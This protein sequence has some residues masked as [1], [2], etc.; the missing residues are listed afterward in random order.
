G[1]GGH[2]F[3]LVAVAKKIK[4]KLGPEVEFLY[5]GSGAEMEKKVMAEEGIK[6]KFVLSGKIRR[7]FSLK[8]FG[9]FFKMPIGFLQALWIL[10]IFAPDA[11]FSKGG[12]VAVPVVLAAW[13]YRIPILMHESDSIPGVANQFLSKLA[14]RV[15]VAYPSAEQYFPAEKV[16]LTGNPIRFEVTEGDAMMLRTQLEFTAGRKTLLVLGGSLGSQAINEALTNILPQLLHSYQIIHQTGAQ[17]FDQTVAEAA[18]QGVKAGH[19][20]YWAV[21]FLNANQMRDAFALADLVISRAGANAIAEI[22]A[23]G[24]SAILIPLENSANGHQEMNAFALAKIGAALVLEQPNLGQH[25]LLEEIEKLMKDDDLR[26]KMGQQIKTFY[27]PN[28][29]DVLANGVIELA[30]R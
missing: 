7:Y 14:N 16:A 9:D 26:T 24:K 6:T 2:L 3:P 30:R 1:T 17:N 15:A 22:A 21:P 13:L 28:A 8:N 25:L 11:V 12:F 18:R 27:H 5:V 4:E 10:F 23:N 19:G 29:A 20:G